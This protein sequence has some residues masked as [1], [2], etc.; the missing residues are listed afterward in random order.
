MQARFA[1]AGFLAESYFGGWG[2]ADVDGLQ[3][4]VS[5]VPIL[6]TQS[7]RH[8]QAQAQYAKLSEYSSLIRPPGVQESVAVFSHNSTLLHTKQSSQL[9]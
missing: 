8:S 4:D 1:H 3:P 9:C 2:A 7:R 6:V 5:K